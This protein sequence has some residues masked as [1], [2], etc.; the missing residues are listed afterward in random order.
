MRHK[1]AAGNLDALAQDPGVTEFDR[2][3]LA[4]WDQSGAHEEFDALYQLNMC[5]AGAF[6]K[7]RHSESFARQYC[8]T[9]LF[10]S[11]EARLQ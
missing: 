4:G 5:P 11:T 7:V 3:S 6:E 8:F 10:S 2:S 9:A 1:D